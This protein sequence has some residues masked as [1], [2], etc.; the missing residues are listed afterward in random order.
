VNAVESVTSVERPSRMAARQADSES[1][2]VLAA[3]RKAYRDALVD[4]EQKGPQVGGP[5]AAQRKALSELLAESGFVNVI[6][7]W[8]DNFETYLSR[9]PFGIEV[10]DL[11]PAVA[12]E[13]AAEAANRISESP[14]QAELAQAQVQP[15]AAVKLLA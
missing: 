8:R 15:P 10:V 1:I 3:Q 2:G 9:E 7:Q 4:A 13:I 14:I 12:V 6:G 11:T 5:L